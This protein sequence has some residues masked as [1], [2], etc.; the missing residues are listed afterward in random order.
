MIKERQGRGVWSDVTCL[1]G[2]GWFSA[3]FVHL[4]DVAATVL[5]RHTN[6]AGTT[7]S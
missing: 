5:A 2:G 1:H 3:R 7:S 6:V 4:S